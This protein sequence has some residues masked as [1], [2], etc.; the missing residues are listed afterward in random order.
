M[1]I[2]PPFVWSIIL[3]DLDS[4]S[5]PDN[6]CYAEYGIGQYKDLDLTFANYLNHTSGQIICNQYLSSTALAV[7][8]NKPFL[9][10]ETN[11]ASCGGF[12]GISDSFGAALWALDYGL[13]M[14]YSN[15]SGAMLHVGGQN[16]FYSV[17]PL[18]IPLPTQKIDHYCL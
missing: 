7:A 15:F 6:N 13:Q 12:A 8:A 1:G 2:S 11:T 9:M 16:V 18:V 4:P 17:R 10:F 3:T 5:Y 14:A